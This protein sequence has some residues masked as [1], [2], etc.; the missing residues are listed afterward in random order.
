M[1]NRGSVTRSPANGQATHGLESG[2]VRAVIIKSALNGTWS[3]LGASGGR[4]FQSKDDA[5]G[6]SRPMGHLLLEGDHTRSLG[7]AH[8]SGLRSRRAVDAERRR[9]STSPS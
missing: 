6:L 3:A 4:G 8:R 1:V 2:E 9:K 7:G 5:V